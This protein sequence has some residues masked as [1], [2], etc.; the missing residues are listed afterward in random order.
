[1]MSPPP[2]D[3]DL[4][5]VEDLTVPLAAQLAGAGRSEIADPVGLAVR[6]DQVAVPPDLDRE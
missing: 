2:V 5:G 4:G 1:M 6:A 3:W